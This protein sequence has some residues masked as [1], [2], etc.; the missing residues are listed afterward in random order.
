MGKMALSRRYT[1]VRRSCKVEAFGRTHGLI[2]VKGGEEPFWTFSW[3][4]CC[5]EALTNQCEVAQVAYLTGIDTLCISHFSA[6]FHGADDAL[7][8]LKRLGEEP[9]LG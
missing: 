4:Q 8:D 9:S 7:S 6:L 3:T 1:A 5:A 2:L